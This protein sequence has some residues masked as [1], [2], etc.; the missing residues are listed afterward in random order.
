MFLFLTPAMFLHVLLNINVSVFSL[1]EADHTTDRAWA[2][3]AI[4]VV[5]RTLLKQTCKTVSF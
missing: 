1:Q 2:E 5:Q 3:P 4:V